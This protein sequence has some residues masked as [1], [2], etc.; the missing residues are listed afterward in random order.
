MEKMAC[1]EDLV[2]QA[3][4]ESEV[5][6]E[7]EVFLEMLLKEHQDRRV[8][9]DQEVKREEMVCPVDLAF[10]ELKEIKDFLEVNVQLVILDKRVN[11][12]FPVCLE[13]M[14]CPEKEVGLEESELMEKE[15]TTARQVCQVNKECR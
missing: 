1:L 2:Y 10:L 13:K 7:K 4:K 11:L 8:P 14:V 5:I 9:Q 6:Q 15:V 3:L 12:E